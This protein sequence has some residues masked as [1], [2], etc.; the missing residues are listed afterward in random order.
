MRTPGLSPVIKYALFFICLLVRTV[1]RLRRILDYPGHCYGDG[2]GRMRLELKHNC[3]ISNRTAVKTCPIRKTDR[4]ETQNGHHEQ[5][6]HQNRS[7]RKTRPSH[8]F[9][10]DLLVRTFGMMM[11]SFFSSPTPTII[12]TATS[13]KSPFHS[14][15]H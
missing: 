7:P 14:S 3:A 10:S 9:S 6:N 8:W 1:I 15:C 12:H 2:R 4:S 11:A 5:Y 13:S